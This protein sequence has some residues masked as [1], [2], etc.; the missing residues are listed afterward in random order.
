MAEKCFYCINEI[1]E[2]QLHQVTFISSNKERHE[3][4]CHECYQEWLQGVKG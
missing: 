2:N 4:L 3:T 1:E